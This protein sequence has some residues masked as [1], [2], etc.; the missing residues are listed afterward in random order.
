[1]FRYSCFVSFP[2]YTISY[3]PLVPGVVAMEPSAFL[4]SETCS[5]IVPV[6]LAVAGSYVR[7]G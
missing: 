2:M 5:E 6:T 3:M 7:A 1:M 4:F